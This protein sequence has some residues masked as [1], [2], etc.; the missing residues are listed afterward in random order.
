M[1]FLCVFSVS[2]LGAYNYTAVD[3]VR[4]DMYSTIRTYLT[5]GKTTFICCL[6]TLL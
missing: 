1:R 5:S 3:F 2:V 6:S 4:T